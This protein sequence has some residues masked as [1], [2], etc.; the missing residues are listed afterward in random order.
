MR[1]REEP[2]N[3]AVASRDGDRYFKLDV[4]G[5]YDVGSRLG[6][7]TLQ[8]GAN[9]LLDATPPVVYNAA[10]A[11]SDAATYDFIGRMAYVR[12]TQLF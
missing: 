2:R 7:T 3:L 10:A 6:K 4:F 5:G 12:L 11:N 8:I 1:S 9:N